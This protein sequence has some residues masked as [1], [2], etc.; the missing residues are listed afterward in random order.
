M[1][2]RWNPYGGQPW[3]LAWPASST[4]AD[5][6]QILHLGVSAAQFSTWLSPRR[7]GGYTTTG[8]AG[9]GRLA[10]GK[11]GC[12]RAGEHDA[13]EMRFTNGHGT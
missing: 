6:R 11:S 13:R 7:Q 8:L 12:I 3:F 9:P 10:P 1:W 5:T 2:P 4:S